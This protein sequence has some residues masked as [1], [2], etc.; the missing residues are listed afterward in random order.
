MILPLMKTSFFEV[1]LSG[2]KLFFPVIA[3]CCHATYSFLQ[4][5]IKKHIHLFFHLNFFQRIKDNNSLDPSSKQ[6]ANS[7]SNQNSANLIRL[8]S[9]GDLK[10]TPFVM[11]SN[12]KS[13]TW[14]GMLL[15]LQ[16]SLT[17]FWVRSR[18]RLT[19][20]ARTPNTCHWEESI[21]LIFRQVP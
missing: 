1:S 14:N 2:E 17:S 8:R 10:W 6:R 3:F 11:Q 7:T 9:M 18:S 4:L 13:T 19:F 20:R 5:I 15:P 16:A 21:Y 12:E